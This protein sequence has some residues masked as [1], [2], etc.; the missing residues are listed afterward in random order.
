MLRPTRRAFGRERAYSLP[1]ADRVATPYAEMKALARRT[2]F[3]VIAVWVFLFAFETLFHGIALR[4]F[5]AGLTG[6][7]TEAEGVQM[8]PLLV[9]GHLVL[10]V[11]LVVV[12]CRIAKAE[13]LV[14]AAAVGALLALTFGGGSSLLQYA[15]Q[16]LPP[17]LVGLWIA[18]GV[19]EFAL[20]GAV[21]RLVFGRP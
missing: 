15:A 8:L 20:G 10:A 2:V 9:A 19:V 14:A 1:H 13:N 12:V 7:R 16:D 3:A 5:Y 17:A 4:D 11:G 18:G 6:F 21:A